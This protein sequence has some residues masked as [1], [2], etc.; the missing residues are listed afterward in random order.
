M[1]WII[2][3]PLKKSWD[4]ELVLWEFLITALNLLTILVKILHIYLNK[5]LLL[6]ISNNIMRIVTATTILIINKFSAEI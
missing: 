3:H 2:S 5:V 6:K 1:K 4:K